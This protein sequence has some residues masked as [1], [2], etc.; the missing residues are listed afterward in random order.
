M[1]NKFINYIDTRIAI[2]AKAGDFCQLLHDLLGDIGW[3]VLSWIANET[4]VYIFS[5]IIRNYLLGISSHRDLDVVVKSASS[6]QKRLESFPFVT[7]NQFGGYKI[8][9]S[10]ID[11]D[12]WEL[13]RT[14]G[15]REQKLN[16]T[17][18][19]LIHTAFFNFSSLVYD[20]RK[21]SFMISD[22]FCYFYNTKEMDLIFE[23]N[24]CPELCIVNSLYYNTKYKFKLSEKLCSWLKEK[25]RLIE[26]KNRFLD[27]QNRHFHTIYFS[28]SD[29]KNFIDYCNFVI[30]M[31]R[32][33]L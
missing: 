15:I 33:L 31:N 26:D 5:G 11:I 24:P 8:W 2:Q 4:E 7:K 12:L 16:P 17:P 10:N 21:Q 27:V 23:L 22:D 25:Y 29:I 13:D 28:L 1:G 6:F 32:T 19:S 3:K 18:E 9:F 20:V 14:W 30:Y